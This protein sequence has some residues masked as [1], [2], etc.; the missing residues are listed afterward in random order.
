[1]SIPFFIFDARKT[2]R[3]NP[4]L[5]H[6]ISPSPRLLLVSI[7]E[8]QIFRAP[9]PYCTTVR[10][11][12]SIKHVK[13][14]IAFLTA[15]FLLIAGSI[16]IS[17]FLFAKNHNAILNPLSKNSSAKI[18]GAI[19]TPA[20]TPTPTNTPFPTPTPIP[21]TPTATQTPT[22]TP[23]IIAPANLEELFAKYSNE[24]SIDK[25]LM[26]RIAH[27]ESGLNPA[28]A[29]SLYGGLYQFSEF[30]WIST[31]TLTG[32]NSDPNIRFNAE[33]SI[34]TAAFMISQNHLEIWPNCNR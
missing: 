1:M 18:L 7:R 17:Y 27:C 12:G 9:Q 16:T 6:F 19:S 32:H 13:V 29:T 28:A 24:Y 3:N 21:P 8:I 30:L 15:F 33:E 22:L 10:L 2:Q 5:F 25:E 4:D 20:P 23:I 11:C 34:R 14:R 31:R 26:K